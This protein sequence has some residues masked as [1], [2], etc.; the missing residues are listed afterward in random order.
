[1]ILVKSFIQKF[2]LRRYN[3]LITYNQSG[4]FVL[5]YRPQVIERLLPIVEALISDKS[6]LDNNLKRIEG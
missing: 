3:Q 4:C 2:P 1:M 5:N 6:H